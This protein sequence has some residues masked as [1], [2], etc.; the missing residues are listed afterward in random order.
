M[1]RS[2]QRRFL[3]A[4]L[5]VF[6]TVILR[7]EAQMAPDSA[8]Q[9]AG[10]GV[11]PMPASAQP[12]VQEQKKPA[13]PS[14]VPS[15]FVF[16][17]LRDQKNIWSSP[18]KAR[19]QD[20]NWIVPIAGVTAGLINADAELSSRIDTTGTFA[21]HAGTISNAGVALALGGAGGLYLLGKFKTDDRQREAG[22]L[23]IEAGADSLI[24][25]EALKLVARRERPTNGTGQGRFFKN[26]SLLNSSFPS[27]HAMITWSVASAISHEYP[28]RLTQAFT[29]GTATVVSL[30]RVYGKDHFPSDVLVGGIAGW[31]IGREVYASHHDPEIPGG[32]WGT[33]HHDAA[34]EGVIPATP[35]SPY[36]P[37]DSWVYAAFDRLAALGAI[38]SGFASLR[39]WTRAECARLIEEAQGSIDEESGDESARLL[40]SLEKE[41]ARELNGVDAHYVSI[42]SIYSR[43]LGTSGPALTDDYHFGRTVVNDFG[44]PYEQGV[45]SVA[46]FSS[47]GSAGALGFY[48]RGEYE[49]APSAPALQQTVQDA[50]QI[51]DEKP[52]APALATTEFNQFRLIDAYISL[53]INGW[54]TSF[55]KQNLWLGPTQDPMLWSD[56][57]EPIYMLRVDQ[58]TPR[59]LPSLL[60]HLGPLRT[61]FWIGKLAGQHFIS[62]QGPEGTVVVLGRTIPKQP[63]VNGVK[64]NFKP[65]P[66]FDFG[67]GVTALWGGPDFPITL[68]SA[69][70]VLFSTQNAAGRGRDPGDRRSS[71]DFSYRI[72]KLRDHLTLYEDSMV[73]DE[74]S[75]IGYPRRAAH[76]AGLYLSRV[77]GVAHMDF[78]FEGGYTNLPGLIEP[79]G[80]GFFYWNTRFLDGYTVRGNIIGD[81]TVG[82]QGISLRGESTYWFSSDKTIQLGYRSNIADNMFLDGGNLRDIYLRSQWSLHHEVSLS[83]LL[84]YEYWNFPLLSAGNKQ[85]NF[86]AGFQ[87]TYRPHW[88]ISG[89]S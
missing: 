33:F 11:V 34:E 69:R 43:V 55:G 31:L 2:A 47:S 75:P 12:A 51:A 72:P 7:S 60:R 86:T 35:F 36:V 53:N 65:T 70:H 23:G 50:I 14:A 20:L 56:N 6:S 88:R 15:Q 66:N 64:L 44:R 80:G 79:P 5:L 62:T 17:V 16:N 26:G 37:V 42:D 67:V 83:S 48:V 38:H 82:R 8:I 49:H 78:R 40:A 71:F 59:Q 13:L 52:P 21:R 87:L 41:F 29:Y 81:A 76:D 89:G 46:G 28:G 10:S 45:N 3:V 61:E 68:G 25:T 9:Q 39:P 19:I 30:A 63:M 54:Q 32:G 57:A 74:I 27:A 85:S 24:V 1:I 58:T 77:P 18:F 73:E 22:T 4:A 84:Q